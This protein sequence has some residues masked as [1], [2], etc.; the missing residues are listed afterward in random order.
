MAKIK[1]RKIVVKCQCS[2]CEQ[3]AFVEPGKAHHFCRGI[4]QSIVDKLPAQF[5]DLTNPKRKGV[6]EIAKVKA[7]PVEL[8]QESA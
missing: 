6:W 8:I 3:V 4:E 1:P 5:K 7:E 2:V